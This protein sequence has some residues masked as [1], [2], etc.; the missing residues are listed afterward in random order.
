MKESLIII[1]LMVLVLIIGT[2][3]T[4]SKGILLMEEKMDMV[5]L[6]LRM[7]RR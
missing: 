2:M 7:E 5:F 3:V 1:F 4:N 6:L